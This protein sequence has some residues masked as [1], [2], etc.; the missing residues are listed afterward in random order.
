MSTKINKDIIVWDIETAYTVAAVWGLYEQNVAKV[1]REPYIISVAWKFL[2]DKETHVVALPDFPLYKKDK[3]NDKQLVEYLHNLFSKVEVVIA[4]NNNAFDY[5][6][7]TG[8]F[9]VHSLPPIPPVQSVDTLLI[10][11]SKFKFNSHK[12]KDLGKYFNLGDKLDTGGIDLW[13]KCIELDDWKSWDLMKKY[14]KQDVVLLEKVYLHMLP[15]ITNHPNIAVINGD[16]IA[17]PNC[18]SLHMTVS[19]HRYTRTGMKIQLQ[20]Q[21]CGS[22]HTRPNREGSQVR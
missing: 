21:N 14:N 10:A 17:C 8:R 19:K 22:Y 2:G 3:H 12:L 11:R 1:I 13:Y 18:G 7:V 9:A 6:W 4:H 16:R 15:F 20:C 5:K